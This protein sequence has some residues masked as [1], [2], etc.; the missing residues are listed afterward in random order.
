MPVGRVL[1]EGWKGLRASLD[2]GE[3]KISCPCQESNHSPQI[4]NMMSHTKLL[5]HNIG[6]SVETTEM[7]VSDV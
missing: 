6:N 1:L 7:S 3:E 2:T 5:A 4:L